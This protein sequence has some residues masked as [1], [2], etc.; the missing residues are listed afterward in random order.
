MMR[1]VNKRPDGSQFV[2]AVRLYLQG[3]A[4]WL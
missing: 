1:G 4:G 3:E 2:R